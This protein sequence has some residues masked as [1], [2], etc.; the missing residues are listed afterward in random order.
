MDK[1]PINEV[2]A[3]NLAY[4][5]KKRGFTQAALAA[6]VGLAQRTI[7]NYLKPSLRQAES[8][9]GK[10]PS[11]KLTE[12]EKIADGLEVQVWE[13]LRPISPKE[14]DLYKRIEDS[15]TQLREM[16]AENPLVPPQRKREREEDP[17]ARP[18]LYDHG[19]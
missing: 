11:A 4:F 16:A 9:S 3:V 17:K 19:W 1:L 12:V 14:R 8:K 7:G 5:M 10:A 13:L 15:F 18:A 2:L 6:R